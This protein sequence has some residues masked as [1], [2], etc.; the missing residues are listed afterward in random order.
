MHRAGKRFAITSWQHLV[1]QPT[2]TIPRKQSFSSLQPAQASPRD[3][4]VSSPRRGPG[5]APNFDGILGG[6][7]SWV[8]RRRASEASLKAGP[9]MA[10]EPS[11]DHQLDGKGV[12]I[13]EEEEEDINRNSQLPGKSLDPSVVSGGK[14]PHT[15]SRDLNAGITN[16]SL[17]NG[18][19]AAQ[20]HGISSPL[21][22]VIDHATIEWSYK[23]PSGQIQGI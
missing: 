13:P 11:G 1:E 5:Y 9:G 16:L 8:A 7:E 4:N 15:G 19:N 21:T 10:R 6:G 22:G 2:I 23:D 18:S 3:T 12:E 14:D 20:S 17:N